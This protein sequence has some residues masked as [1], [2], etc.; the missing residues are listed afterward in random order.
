[1]R[2]CPFFIM[3]TWKNRLSRWWHCLWRFHK[4]ADYCGP[5]GKLWAIGCADCGMAKDGTHLE[6]WW[7]PDGAVEGAVKICA[8]DVNIGPQPKRPDFVDSI[9]I[10]PRR[11]K[12]GELMPGVPRAKITSDADTLALV[13]FDQRVAQ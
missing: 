7:K 5:G 10:S 2:D 3:P 11:P 4:P 12:D 6:F 13:N 8:E 1:M 9:R